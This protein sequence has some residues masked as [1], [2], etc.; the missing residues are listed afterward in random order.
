M[1]FDKKDNIKMQ[2]SP[3]KEKQIEELIDTKRDVLNHL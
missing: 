3:I 2:Q 1:F